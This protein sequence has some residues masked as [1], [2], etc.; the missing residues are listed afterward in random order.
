MV[1]L[2]LLGPAVTESLSLTTDTKRVDLGLVVT[3]GLVSANQKLNLQVISDLR[4]AAQA[5]TLT[6]HLLRHATRRRRDESRRGLEGLRDGHVAI[7]HVLEVSL[8]RDVDAGGII[9]PCHVHLVDVVGGVALK[10]GII[11]VLF[12]CAAQSVRSFSSPSQRIKNDSHES[13][14]AIAY[15][16]LIQ[17]LRS[18]ILS[19][20]IRQTVHKCQRSSG[21]KAKLRAV[22]IPDNGRGK[23]ERS[24]AG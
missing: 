11:G 10:E 24:P 6:G 8:P 9:L 7:F 5:Q 20:T 21:R 2:E 23:R 4:A 3:T 12:E 15:H 18:S 13:K 19:P 16:P 1:E 14:T 22:G 17:I